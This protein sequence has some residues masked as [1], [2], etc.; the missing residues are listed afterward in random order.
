MK[1]RI[2]CGALSVTLLFGSAAASFTDISSPNVKQAAAVLD[3]LQ[4]MQGEGA[5]RFNPNGQLTR[6]QFCKLA[7]TALGV[8]DVSVYKNYSVFPDVPSS[9]WAAGYINAALKQTDIAEKKIIRGFANGTFGPDK[10]I[11]Y[12]E[13]CTMLLRMLGYTVDDVGPFWP[14][15]YIGKA[16]GL[17]LN[18]GISHYGSNEIVKRGDAAVMLLNTLQATPKKDGTKLLM[19]TVATSTVEDSILLATAETDS[20][21]RKGQARFYESGAIQIRSLADTLDRA[22]IG[23]R[24]TVLFDKVTTNKVR[25]FVPKSA[26]SETITVKQAYADHIE[27]TDQKL[28][29]PSKTPV[30][31]NGT[32]IEYGTAWPDLTPDY[33]L[34]IFYDSGRQIEL[35]SAATPVSGAS[36]FVY[37]MISSLKIPADYKIMKNGVEIERTALRQYDLVSLNAESKS[38][39][40]SDRRITGYL[41]SAAPSY[42]HPSRVT[43]LGREFPISDNVASY[44]TGMKFNDKVTLLLDSFGTVQA[45]YPA[46]TVST[47]NIGVFTASTSDKATVQLLAG[48]SASGELSSTDSARL[49]GQLVRVSADSNGK[50]LLTS[51]TSLNAADGSWS[52]AS[53]TL[54]KRK[55]AQNV[56]IYETVADRAPIALISDR[57]LNQA[58][59]AAS[60]IR[61]VLLDSAGSV[62][63]IFLRDVTGLGWQYGIA[64]GTRTKGDLID[65]STDFKT[66]E[67]A[68]KYR[69][70]PN[71]YNYSNAIVFKTRVNGEMVTRT[72]QVDRLPSGLSGSPMGLPKGMDGI[73]G[74]LYDLPVKK[75]ATVGSV[76]VNAF[77][78]VDGVKTSSGYLTLPEDISVYASDTEKMISLRDAKLNYKDFTLYG[79]TSS[80]NGARVY[81]ILAK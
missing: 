55:V 27:T 58:T 60:D 13:A 9:H 69:D 63:S 66:D 44:F 51:Y 78:G 7:V 56:K 8:S 72:Y 41:R 49:L 81:M 20:D 32:L 80:S 45:A 70:N 37:G 14:T 57:D 54:G 75:L 65:P 35:I 71:N 21:L 31:L 10:T 3:A 6:A 79:D 22:L 36:S 11:T 46:S 19:N 76:G 77:D 40:A 24:G 62:T 5:G 43:V 38:A 48:V 29:V 1:K 4:I 18:R 17:G 33:A 68:Q 2:L 16:E 64:Y 25:A 59:I 26:D 73:T 47:D 67:E 50:L 52:I 61:G 30:V 39:I 74:M 28:K 15:D 23:T 42:S 34:N 53:R 12:G